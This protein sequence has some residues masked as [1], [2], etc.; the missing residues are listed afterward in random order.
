MN[1]NKKKQPFTVLGRFTILESEKGDVE[2]CRIKFHNT[3]HVAV[4]PAGVVK[5][6]D[7]EDES[8]INEEEVVAVTTE[9]KPE[10]HAEPSTLENKVVQDDITSIQPDHEESESIE[11]EPMKAEV[12][13]IATNPDGEEIPVEDLEAF[14][15]E[16]DFDMEAV[17]ACL[18]GEQKTHKKWRFA[19]T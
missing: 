8:I 19:T 7:F 5:S 3:G 4:I 16:H 10:M 12:K 13:I 6:N 1:Y 18:A 11:E 2:Y 9:F 17:E 15:A 14:V